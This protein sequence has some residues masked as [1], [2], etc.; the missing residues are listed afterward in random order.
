M[1][2]QAP[3][4][5]QAWGREGGTPTSERVGVRAGWWSSAEGQRQLTDTLQGGSSPQGPPTLQ[6]QADASQQPNP[7]QSE[8][9]E[10]RALSMHF[11]QG[12]SQPPSGQVRGTADQGG[13]GEA[14]SSPGGNMKTR[15]KKS[16]NRVHEGANLDP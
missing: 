16:K 13:S 10:Y 15:G 9:R 14:S 3:H 8:A 7:S 4:Q 2:L 1:R 11:M 6:C 12:V 5:L